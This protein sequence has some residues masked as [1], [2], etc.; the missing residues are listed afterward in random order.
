MIATELIGESYELARNSKTFLAVLLARLAYRL[1]NI[2]P[3]PF[4]GNGLW[5]VLF[6]LLGHVQV[7]TVRLRVLGL[8]IGWRRLLVIIVVEQLRP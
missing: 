1:C 5:G 8:G 6:V 3:R 7:L 2:R 4:L